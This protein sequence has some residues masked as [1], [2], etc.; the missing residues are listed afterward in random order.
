MDDYN[1][2]EFHFYDQDLELRWTTLLELENMYEVVDQAYSRGQV[3]IAFSGGKNF[4]KRLIIHRIDLSSHMSETF[5]IDTFFPEVVSYLELFGNTLVLGGRE[6]SKPSIVFYPL[7]NRRPVILQGFYEKNILIHDI[8]IDEENELFSVLTGYTG[9]THPGILKIRSYDESG[10]PVEDIRIDPDQGK[11]FTHAKSIIANHEYRLVAGLYRE[12]NAIYASGIFLVS[13]HLDGSREI[14]YYPFT[15]LAEGSISTVSDSQEIQPGETDQALTDMDRYQW[16]TT[17]L[18]EFRDENIMLLES[19]VMGKGSG[20]LMD[21]TDIYHFQQGVMVVFDDDLKISAYHPFNLDPL[22]SDNLNA[23]IRVKYYADSLKLILLDGHQVVSK[24]IGRGL[25]DQ[26]L[27]FVQLDQV[28]GK[29]HADA[30]GEQA[31]LL[32]RHW[33]QDYFLIIELETVADRNV[34]YKFL[35][36]KWYNP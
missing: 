6:K 8:Q 10:Q 9:K 34:Q 7:Q 27:T 22:Q 20:S 13:L 1:Q 3:Y 25:K 26:P 2:Y 21:K 23:N 5:E 19:Y 31:I 28:T 12:D 15:D 24:V 29:S 18:N 35:V 36:H 30:S 16:H 14:R 11:V 33:Y 4:K 32:F 17:D